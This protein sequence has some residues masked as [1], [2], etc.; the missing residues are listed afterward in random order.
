MDAVGGKNSSCDLSWQDHVL[1]VSNGTLSYIQEH[2]R[3]I[4]KKRVINLIQIHN[5]NASIQKLKGKPLKSICFG[6]LPPK[7][8]HEVIQWCPT[9]CDPMDCSLPGA[10]LHGILQARVLEWVAISF[11]RGSSWPSDRTW[12]SRIAGRRSNLCAT[13]PELWWG[14]L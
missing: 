11:S 9:L 14:Y 2:Q 5:S 7:W 1:K 8:S 3:P 12:V 13:W 4:C 6:R 10:S